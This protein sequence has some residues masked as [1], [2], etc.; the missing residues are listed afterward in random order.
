MTSISKVV[1]IDKLDNTVNKYNK[2]YH[3]TIKMKS[4][5]VNSSTYIDSSKENIDEDP[6]CIVRISE[7]ENIFVTGYTPNC[8]EEVFVIKKLKN[9]VPWTYVISDL[10]GREILGTFC[11]GELQK[12]KSKKL[13]AEE[14]TKT[15]V[16]KLYV[17]GKGYDH[18]FNNWIDK[19]ENINE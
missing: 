14:V 1:C 7:Y 5:D 19:E 3:S 6:K 16:D 10:K 15:K 2:T 18:S 11:Q 17:N 8:P 13:R 9:S 4:A 12:D